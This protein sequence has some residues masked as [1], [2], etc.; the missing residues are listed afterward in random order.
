MNVTFKW[1]VI[2]RLDRSLRMVKLIDLMAYTN[3]RLIG[4]LKLSRHSDIAM[5]PVPNRHL[6]RSKS[7]TKR[8]NIVD[9]FLIYDVNCKQRLG[10]CFDVGSKVYSHIVFGTTE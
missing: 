9:F 6:K 1:V 4:I 2:Y 10:T 8:R 7:R 3:T 5:Q